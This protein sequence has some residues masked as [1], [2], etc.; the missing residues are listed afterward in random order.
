VRRHAR[1]LDYAM[2]DGCNARTFV[3]VTGMPQT[4]DGYVLRA[5][6]P[7]LT[8]KSWPE[9]LEV[10]VTRGADGNWTAIELRDVPAERQVFETL[11][12]LTLHPAH[13]R[14]EF[15]TWGDDDCCLPQGATR[16]SLRSPGPAPLQLAVGDL[17]LLEEISDASGSAADAERAHRHVV[18]LTEVTPRLDPLYDENVVD[19][20]WAADDA[21]PFALCLWRRAPRIGDPAQPVSVARG[22]VVL[23]DHGR[24]LR[25]EALIPDTLR[26]TRRDRPRLARTDVTFAAPFDAERARAEPA[27]ALMSQ[28]PRGA[29]PVVGLRH[30]D[31]TW[32]VRRDLLRSDRFS[33]DFVVETE[34]DGRAYL[35]FGDGV[36]GRRPAAG[37]Q[38][39]ADYRIG[40]GAAG[41]VG[42]DTLRLLVI[43]SGEP[44]KSADFTVTNPLPAR[45]GVAA[46]AIEHVRQYAP[47]AFRSQQRAV[48]PADYAALAEQHAEVQKAVASQRWTGS[49]YAVFVTVDRRGGRRVD[50]Q[51][52]E[53]LRAY[54]EPYRLMGHDLEIEAP[55]MVALDI[56]LRVCVAPGFLRSAVKKALLDVFSSRER[57][58]G[59]RGLF[60]PDE[61]TF[62]QTVYLSAV[63]AA[64]MRVPG[65]TWVEATR[66]QRWGEADRGER[67]AGRIDLGRLE[68][69]RL[70]NDPNAPA[71]GRLDLD[72]QGGL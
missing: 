43:P 31:D 29:L 8:G 65:V 37:T 12:D 1:L 53:D 64:A 19:V 14:I 39:R 57:P 41:N 69:A 50:A 67:A 42:A 3:C 28:D 52:E 18:R 63:I 51:F 59:T 32:T 10:A 40:G 61:L 54:L 48:I 21:L 9:T 23:A 58:D 2:H 33:E 70:D 71:N 30:G 45:G 35:R 46:E 4:A 17:L 7:L 34:G 55:R 38:F 24:T 20:A 22:N 68:I 66:F 47:Q 26:G 62:G 27:A 16:A 44:F 56:A 13:T 5:T 36:L 60:H 15:Y 49:G 72:M 25:D 6:T 11:H